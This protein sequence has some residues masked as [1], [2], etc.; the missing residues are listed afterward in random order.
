MKKTTTSYFNIIFIFVIIICAALSILL[1]EE[2]DLEEVESY[3]V[4][5]EV[6][7][8]TT[9]KRPR[10]ERIFSIE[11]SGESCRIAVTNDQYNLYNQGDILRVEITVKRSPVLGIQYK[12]YK[13]LGL[14]AV[15]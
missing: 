10:F 15:K 7:E 3:S 2:L 9:Q 12:F 8:K 5:M 1:V 11:G 14:E 4:G 6:I 13:I